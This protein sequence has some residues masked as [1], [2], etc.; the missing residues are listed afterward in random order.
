MRVTTYDMMTKLS[1]G[2][3]CLCLL[4]LP[5]RPSQINEFSLMVRYSV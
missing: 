2:G 5:E 1:L 4:S 3:C